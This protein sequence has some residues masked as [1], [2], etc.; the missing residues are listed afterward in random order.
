MV[1][2]RLWWIDFCRSEFLVPSSTLYKTTLW[3]NGDSL[4]I[5][6]HL[7]NKGN[8]R[9]ALWYSFM[10]LLLFC[11]TG[12]YTGLKIKN[13]VWSQF[14]TNYENLVVTL[15]ILVTKL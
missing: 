1:F 14:A 8:D 15:K 10:K 6:I 11:Y 5:G 7:L 13:N 4:L 2:S 12:L 3:H 9:C